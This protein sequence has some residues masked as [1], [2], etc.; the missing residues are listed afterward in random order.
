MELM[1]HCTQRKN[2]GAIKR[3]GLIPRDTTRHNYP[4][5]LGLNCGVEA[6]Y[7]ALSPWF[8]GSPD[9]YFKYACVAVDVTGLKVE[10]DPVLGGP[11]RRCLDRITPDRIVS[12][13]RTYEDKVAA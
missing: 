6:V 12:V 5:L 8:W 13:L 4:G 1:Y 11:A 7:L 9:G 3:W 2:L 10:P